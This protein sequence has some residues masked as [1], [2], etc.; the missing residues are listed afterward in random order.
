MQSLPVVILAAI[1]FISLPSALPESNKGME[2]SV[3]LIECREQYEITRG[4]KV[5][6][7]CSGIDSDS[8]LCMVKEK[9]DS[10][11]EQKALVCG[12]WINRYSF[13]PS[14]GGR[15]FTVNPFYGKGDMVALANKC[16]GEVL[17][18]TTERMQET[19]KMDK[20]KQTEL[21][22]YLDTHNV[23][24]EGYNTMAEYAEEN[25]RRRNTLERSIELLEKLG[26]GKGVRVRK[27]TFYALL[28]PNGGKKMARMT[29]C[30]DPKESKRHDRGT[31][32]LR[33]T[34][35]FMPESCNSVYPFCLIDMSPERGDSVQVAA[36]FGLSLRNDVNKTAVK[37]NV[38][39][40]VAT[41]KASHDIPELLAPDGSPVF[42]S[43]GFFV[44]I[45]YKGRIA[46]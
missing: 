36:V 19:L 29:C 11:T 23:S 34:D 38:F 13:M 30:I 42:S 18:K 28:Y 22:Y 24:D 45:S 26:D 7:V 15:I 39:R 43:K 1:A 21:D 31:V 46:K 8:T 35:G 16:I 32:V 44:G 3:A 40:G 12:A 6:A 37:P 17:Q 27:R 14:C 25:K 10:D 33:T 20:T 41:S 4:G 5:V 2:E 9:A